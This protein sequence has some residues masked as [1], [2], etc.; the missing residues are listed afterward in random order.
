MTVKQFQLLPDYTESRFEHDGQYISPSRTSIYA[1]SQ[2]GHEQPSETSV[3]RAS[4]RIVFRSRRCSA[5]IFATCRFSRLRSA[6]TCRSPIDSFLRC[7]GNIAH[8]TRRIDK[9]LRQRDTPPE[10][11]T[12]CSRTRIP[13]V[14]LRTAI[15]SPRLLSVEPSPDMTARR[16]GCGG[17]DGSD[18]FAGPIHCPGPIGVSGSCG[19][20]RDSSVT[21]TDCSSPDRTTV[22]STVSPGAVSSARYDNSCAWF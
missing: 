7:C 11:G 1:C 22:S 8:D 20:G 16:R 2:W 17:H 14:T 19:S 9:R 6:A 18:Q 4:P 12:R 15:S 3:S 21:S 13:A 5:S 10:D